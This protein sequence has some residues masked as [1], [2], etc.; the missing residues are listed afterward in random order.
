MKISIRRAQPEEI[1]WINEQ[2]D[3]LRFQRSDYGQEIIAIAEADGER[4][5][6]GQLVWLDEQALEL[7]GMYVNNSFRG[8]GLARHLVEYLKQQA[9]G[10]PVYCMPF[11]HLGDF[12]GS[13]GFTRVPQVTAAPAKVLE[14]WMWYNKTYPDT[15]L[16]LL[17]DV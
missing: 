9:P 15:S 4:A 12:Y 7:G 14:K 3:K 2:Y 16:L 1:T 10:K 11:E 6:I 17:L 13:C 5:G 8:G